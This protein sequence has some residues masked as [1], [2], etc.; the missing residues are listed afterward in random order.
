MR[1]TNSDQPPKKLSQQSLPELNWWKEN[2]LLQNGKPL[3]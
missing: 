3:K 2:L 1:E